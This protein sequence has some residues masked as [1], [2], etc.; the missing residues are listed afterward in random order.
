MKIVDMALVTKR[1]NCSLY[2]HLK[3]THQG[4]DPLPSELQK[5]VSCF[6]P[7]TQRPSLAGSSSCCTEEKKQ[8]RIINL[9]TDL[10]IMSVVLRACW[11]IR[12]YRFSDLHSY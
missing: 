4:E 7:L 8:N 2:V 10:K 6:R 1:R 12:L 9:G 11:M 3:C 5:Q